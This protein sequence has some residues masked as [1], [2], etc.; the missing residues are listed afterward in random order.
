[1]KRKNKDDGPMFRCPNCERVFASFTQATHFASCAQLVPEADE[2]PARDFPTL[3]ENQEM[4]LRIGDDDFMY[5]KLR[6]DAGAP[7]IP[8]WFKRFAV[9][10]SRFR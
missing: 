9:L 6:I 3:G 5:L 10:F 4:S 8:G 1:M 7:D 2:A